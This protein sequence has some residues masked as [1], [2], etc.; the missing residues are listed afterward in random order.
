MA[1]DRLAFLRRRIVEIEGRAETLIDAPESGAE[2][3]S[4]AVL[5]FGIAALDRLLAGGLRRAALHEIRG[6]AMRDASAVTGFALAL[7]ARLARRDPRP[8]LLVTEKATVGEAGFPY[9]PALDGFGLPAGR[10]IVVRAAKPQEALWAFEEGLR[11]RGLAAALA[12]LN[13][14]PRALDLTASRRLA[15]RAG[16]EGVTGL[17]VR[18]AGRPEPGAA[19]TR[20]CVT[21]RPSALPDGFPEG[22]GRPAWH[23]DL[24]RNRSGTTG[25]FDLEWDHDRR[26]FALCETG[27]TALPLPRPAASA[28]RPHLASAAG[29]RLALR[30]AS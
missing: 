30:R 23:L 2:A 20:W 5:P 1:G 19:T 21:P 13:G 29:T 4:R 25:A 10:L 11:C 14:N 18:Q 8:V 3:D 16:E 27:G 22:I 24:E 26:A 7:L 17:L 12:E 9:G 15:L 6:G 28:D